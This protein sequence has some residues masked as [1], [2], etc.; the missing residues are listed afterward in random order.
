[1]LEGPLSFIYQARMYPRAESHYVSLAHLIY[2]LKLQLQNN[3]QYIILNT[4]V[5]GKSACG[6]FVTAKFMMDT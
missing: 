3:I 4:V 5:R 1:M 2:K 6:L